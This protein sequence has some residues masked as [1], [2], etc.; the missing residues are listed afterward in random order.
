MRR[1]KM[2][3]WTYVF[4][5]SVGVLTAL[6]VV[7]WKMTWMAPSWYLP[8]SG[9]AVRVVERADQ[10]ENRLMQ[11][12]HQV[13]PVEEATWTLRI[14]EEDINAWFA[15]RLRKWVAH[16]AGAQWPA[17]LG[18]PQVRFEADAIRLA[19]PFAAGGGERFVIA[20]IRPV[21]EKD[22]LR[23][24]L[25]R[26]ELGRVSLPGEPVAN[27]LRTLTGA[28]PGAFENKELKSVLDWLERREAVEP[29]VELEDGRRIRIV[30][31]VMGEGM[32]D[33]T[34][35]TVDR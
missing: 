33:V 7:I 2:K 30:K 12:T 31:I 29:M 10:V 32:V 15:A 25:K 17:E 18:T 21:M 16:E 1:R 23:L 20:A 34:A 14:R 13:R 5:G 9:S 19:I 8:P 6:G 4:A 28:A 22:L 3:R 24:E 35:R 27:L 26:V 11:V